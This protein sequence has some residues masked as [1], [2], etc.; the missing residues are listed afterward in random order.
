MEEEYNFLKWSSNIKNF[1]RTLSIEKNSQPIKKRII[2]LNCIIS[3]NTP[4]EVIFN[5]KP[6][7]QFKRDPFQII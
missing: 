6:N 1:Y 2:A 4:R 5:H 7:I 3:I